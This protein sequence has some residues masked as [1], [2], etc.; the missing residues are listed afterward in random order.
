MT[1]YVTSFYGYVSPSLHQLLYMASLLFHFSLPFSNIFIIFCGHVQLQ[2]THISCKPVRKREMFFYFVF[3]DNLL[4]KAVCF[5][6]FL[7]TLFKCTAPWKKWIIQSH[8]CLDRRKCVIIKLFLSLA[9]NDNM[10][11]LLLLPVHFYQSK[12][13]LVM[14]LIMWQ[15]YNL[16]HLLNSWNTSIYEFV[17][18]I[19]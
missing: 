7:P 10:L 9:G 19:T 5:H 6:V 15:L 16:W 17:C 2:E 8:L 1:I 4:Q 3:T 14:D 13:F 12:G 11:Q 18:F